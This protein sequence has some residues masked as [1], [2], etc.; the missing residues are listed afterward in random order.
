[1]MKNIFPFG[2]AL[3]LAVGLLQAC[4]ESAED[5]EAVD[6]GTFSEETITLAVTVAEPVSANLSVP[7]LTMGKRGLALKSPA[8]ATEAAEA[9]D[10]IL[11]TADGLLPTIYGC[12]IDETGTCTI[13][14]P[15]SLAEEGGVLVADTGTTIQHA[16]IAMT[17]E[18]TEA[19]QA[20]G[21]PQATSINPVT[22]VTMATVQALLEDNPDTDRPSIIEAMNALYAEAATTTDDDEDTDTVSDSARSLVTAMQDIILDAPEATRPVIL[23]E[24]A[25]ADQSIEGIESLVADSS[26]LADS[27]VNTQETAGV[28]ADAYSNPDDPD[29]P[30]WTEAVTNAAAETGLDTADIAKMIVATVGVSTPEEVDQTG[31]DPF[32]IQELQ[33]MALAVTSVTDLVEKG[34]TDR[35]VPGAIAEMMRL[36]NFAGTDSMVINQAMGLLDAT[37]PTDFSSY[38]AKTAARAALLFNAEYASEGGFLS[39]SEL[40]SVLAPA[41]KD[42][43]VQFSISTGGT[44]AFSTFMA[45]LVT[46]GLAFDASARKVDIFNG[47]GESCTTD[48]DCA[49]SLCVSSV[50]T[51]DSTTI[52]GS[53]DTDSDCTSGE[54]C[55]GRHRNRF[56]MAAN[57]APAGV[58]VFG[59]GDATTPVLRSEVTIASGEAGSDCPCSSGFTCTSSTA[60]A[61]V[62]RPS[63]LTGY[64]APGMTC[65]SA[66][67][68]ISGTCSTGRCAAT[69]SFMASL[70]TLKVI[71]DP[72]TSPMDCQSM[73][74]NAGI[75]DSPPTFIQNLFTGASLAGAGVSC[76]SNNQCKSFFCNA[77]V[78][79]AYTGSGYTTVAETKTSGQTC[80]FTGECVSPLQCVSGT[81][82][83]ITWAIPC[84][85]TSQC[86]ADKYCKEFSC[87]A[88]SSEGGSCTG[89]T[90]STIGEACVNGIGLACLASNS[91]CQYRTLR[92]NT[93]TKYT[94]P[95]TP[96]TSP[97]GSYCLATADNAYTFTSGG[98]GLTAYGAGG[99]GNLTVTLTP[100]GNCTGVL[101][102]QAGSGQCPGTSAGP[103]GTVTGSKI[104]LSF[105]GLGNCQLVLKN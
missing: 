35:K 7:A 89:T 1:M 81:C 4:L 22:T 14:V 103:T 57:G 48:S 63:T 90:T 3:F 74:C 87:V 96:K 105:P 26:T 52:G 66:D 45:N 8:M 53:C 9:G 95:D 59:S 97:G 28:I 83:G 47:P 71:G 10:V 31:N 54:V 76:T 98:P 43:S 49:G 5:E 85:A 78:C 64:R 2:V 13:E 38:N 93:W 23:M 86:P 91:T 73:W 62:C 33:N 68:C 79:G 42:N 6:E 67:Q 32:S 34:A 72:C 92:N 15:V 21:E 37:F 30:V 99:T 51:A 41:L 55:V 27:V 18:E 61:G 46:D 39:P 70:G 69:T 77:G 36:G 25:F 102:G 58:T 44:K 29:G 16:M 50:C 12:T 19:L 104:V 40:A 11:K 100:G 24:R 80:A 75:C 101:N 56:C 20:S 65:T 60:S 84:N 88:R 94:G 82:A 17:P